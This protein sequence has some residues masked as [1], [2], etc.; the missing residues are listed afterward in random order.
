MA[1]GAIP[2]SFPVL[3]RRPRS[4]VAHEKCEPSISRFPR[5]YIA[6]QP[7]TSSDLMNRI[8][9]ASRAPCEGSSSVA[10]LPAQ[11]GDLVARHFIDRGWRVF[12]RRSAS[13]FGVVAPG[14]AFLPRGLQPAFGEGAGRLFGLELF[15]EF[16]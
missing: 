7:K 15:L 12:R 1:C 9:I 2:E 11:A 8:R 3:N 16:G 6:F 5:N 4:R 10:G 13:G 14:A